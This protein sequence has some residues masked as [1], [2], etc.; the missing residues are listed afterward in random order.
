MEMTYRLTIRGDRVLTVHAPD[1]RGRMHEVA[2]V[3]WTVHDVCRTMRKSRRQVYRY[4]RTGRLQPCARV[5]G[6]WLFAPEAVERFRRDAVPSRL[7]P[8]F[9]DVELAQLS[10]ERHRDFILARLLELGDGDAVRWACSVYPRE[11][12]KA[13]LMHRGADLLSTRTWH[14]LAS[15]LGLPRRSR[16][17]ASWRRRSRSWAWRA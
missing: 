2:R 16:P 3:A 1:A 9:W 12:I 14:F 8:F 13:F 17:P 7:R 11:A 10:V 4:L 15:Q 5:L 6:Q